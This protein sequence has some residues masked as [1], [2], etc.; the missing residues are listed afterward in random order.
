M[1]KFPNLMSKLTT[2]IVMTA[3]SSQLSA[4]NLSVF[5]GTA[6]SQYAA[7]TGIYSIE[8]NSTNGEFIDAPG[9]AAELDSPGFI[10]LHPRLP[11]LYALATAADGKGSTMNSF[12]L[13]LAP[14]QQGLEPLNSVDTGCAKATHMD[15]DPSGRMLVSVHY[16][17]GTVA[18]FPLE[19]D[20]RLHEPS[21]VL[22][23]TDSSGVNAGRQ[24]GP[25]P[26]CATF[27][28]SGSFVLIPDLGADTVYIYKVDYETDQLSS[29]RRFKSAPGAG[30]RH[31]KFSRDGRFAYIVNELS[32]TVDTCAW[33]AVS[34]ELKPIATVTSLPA[35]MREPE[36][37]YTASE[38][39][40]H[41][42]GN[43][44]YTAT[45][46]HDSISLFS[47]DPASGIPLLEEVVP[48][49]V[50]WPRHFSLDPKG[51]YL[52]CA[53]Q[54]SHNAN[55]F[56]VDPQSGRLSHL[57]FPPIEVPGPICVLIR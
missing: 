4:D 7:S 34:G 30:P 32:L 51:R 24:K 23:H 41:P 48:A 5:F 6:R 20:G 33:D 44:L 49:R 17:E 11:V 25:H 54:F 50:E 29:H 18:V 35:D 45:R 13:A 43:F 40:L 28:P 12:T 8:L 31:I 55:V 14:G 16:G 42:S 21:Q 56:A 52:V 53:G 22:R 3:L 27:D 1:Y 38:I 57:P 2:L 37:N 15:V 19:A 46:G 10:V 47:I 9:V 26:H 39:Q 36:A